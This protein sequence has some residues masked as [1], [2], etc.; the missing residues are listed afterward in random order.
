MEWMASERTTLC[1]G[2]AAFDGLL[3]GILASRML[4]Q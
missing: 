4:A 2:G 3:A 1:R